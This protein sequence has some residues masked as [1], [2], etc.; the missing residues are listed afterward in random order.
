VTDTLVDT[1]G[2]LQGPATFPQPTFT[3][4]EREGAVFVKLGPPRVSRRNLIDRT[5]ERV[6]PGDAARR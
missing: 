3:V 6:T 5:G 2:P 4:T 1:G